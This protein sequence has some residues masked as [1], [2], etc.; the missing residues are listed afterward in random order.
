MMVSNGKLVFVKPIGKNI[1]NEFEYDL[2]FSEFPDEVWALFW[3]DNNPS[4]CGDLTPDTYDKVLRIKSPFEL[5]TI[6]EM[7]CFSMEHTIN[8]IVALAWVDI[9]VL[10]EFPEYRM[11][12]HFGEEENKVI[13][14]IEKLNNQYDSL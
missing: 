2:L 13:E 12:L 7:S 1:E 8:N 10:E 4:S 5:R 3:D 14:K 6:Q 9:N 11:V